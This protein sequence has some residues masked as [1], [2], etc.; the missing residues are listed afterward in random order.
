ME[1]C[2]VQNQSENGKITAIID[3]IPLLIPLNDNNY[4]DAI[5]VPC[6]VQYLC[7]RYM[8]ILPKKLN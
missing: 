8:I 2:L 6:S 3:E 4:N 5:T 7:S 1:F